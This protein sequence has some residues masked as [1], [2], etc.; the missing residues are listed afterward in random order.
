[1]AVLIDLGEANNLHPHRKKEVGERLAAIALAQTYG[2]KIPYAGPAL[3]A[4]T[5]EG[6]TVRLHFTH[7]EGGLVA[8]PLPK[9]YPLDLGSNAFA[10]LVLHKPNSPLQGFAIC[11]KDG[12]WTWGNA[13][14]DGD[15]VIVESPNVPVPFAV[16]YAWADN[17]TCNLY[18]RAGFPAAPFRTDTFPVLSQSWHL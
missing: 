14:I 12:N 13:R 1:M 8:R 7:C 16:R 3:R 2:M 11:G 4:M 6:K 17:P 10:P 15:T 5:I 9:E 18:N